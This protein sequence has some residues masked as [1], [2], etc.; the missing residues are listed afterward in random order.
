MCR[1][2]FRLTGL[3][4]IWMHAA[5]SSH[6]SQS[7]QVDDLLAAHGG[8]DVLGLGRAQ[9]H[10]ILAFRLPRNRG[11]VDAEDIPRHGFPCVR[12]RR[13]VGVHPALQ[14]IAARCTWVAVHQPFLVR[15]PKILKHVLRCC[16]VHLSRSLNKFAQLRVREREVTPGHRDQEG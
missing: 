7:S 14:A 3:F 1:V 11:V 9:R 8:S 4:A 10:A 2:N 5:L 16:K 12:V 6:T 15:A 13:V